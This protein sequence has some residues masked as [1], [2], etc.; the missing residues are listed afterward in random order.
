MMRGVLEGMLEY[1]IIKL[2]M[3]LHIHKWT[4]G[5]DHSNGHPIGSPHFCAIENKI[6]PRSLL[7]P[8]TAR[9]QMVI[10][11]TTPKFS[12]TQSMFC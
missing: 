11:Q 5:P 7:Y 2:N 6:A 12:V 9:V 10:H 3:Y 8:A 1:I 4:S